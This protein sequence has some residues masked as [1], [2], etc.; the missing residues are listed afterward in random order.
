MATNADNG[1]WLQEFILPPD[2]HEI[3]FSFTLP[4][5]LP[6]SFEGDFGYVRYSCRVTLERPWDF[7]IVAKRAFSVIGIEDINEDT[8]VRLLCSLGCTLQEV[9]LEK[10][11]NYILKIWVFYVFGYSNYFQASYTL[12]LVQSICKTYFY[13]TGLLKADW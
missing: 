7:D 12:I 5:T 2:T 4:K 3:P 8:K 9:D 1:N 11:I 10:F 6:S 13:N